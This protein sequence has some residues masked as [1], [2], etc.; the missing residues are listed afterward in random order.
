M[1]TRS[2]SFPGV[3]LKDLV[4]LQREIQWMCEREKCAKYTVWQLS[5]HPGSNYNP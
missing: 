3:R 2:N 1:T 5:R 4:I